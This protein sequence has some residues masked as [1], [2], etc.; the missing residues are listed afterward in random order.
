M[1]SWYGADFHGKRTSNGEPY[2]MYA[3]TAAHKTLPLRLHVRV[4]NP[5]TASRRGAG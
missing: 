1:A 2:D 3:M 4:T 5:P